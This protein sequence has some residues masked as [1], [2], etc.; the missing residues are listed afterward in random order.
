MNLNLCVSSGKGPTDCSLAVSQRV[1]GHN[2]EVFVSEKLTNHHT[3]H[4]DKKPM[5]EPSPCPRPS[6]RTGRRHK[7]LASERLESTW[8]RQD[9]CIHNE[10]GLCQYTAIFI[11]VLQKLGVALFYKNS[12]DANGTKWFLN[13]ICKQG[14]ARISWI[15][16]ALPTDLVPMMAFM[17]YTRSLSISYR[18]CRNGYCYLH[19]PG[20]ES[21][22]GAQVSDWVRINPPSPAEVLWTP[23]L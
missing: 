2:K 12:L 8:R 13:Q 17:L 16:I 7:P 23:E 3:H 5:T 4:Y 14:R 19:F 6:A 22:V 15:V 18:S 11:S 1:R 21:E 10:S 20:E 9:F